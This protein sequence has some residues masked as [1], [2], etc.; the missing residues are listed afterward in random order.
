M[1]GA[2][3]FGP[4]HSDARAHLWN[5]SFLASA[6]SGRTDHTAVHSVPDL[7]LSRP[8]AIPEG[9]APPFCWGPHGFSP[10]LGPQQV[11][12]DGYPKTWGK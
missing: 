1:G 3:E 9:R 7:S 11:L 12:Q 2:A 6:T 4:W 10:V 5:H 8:R